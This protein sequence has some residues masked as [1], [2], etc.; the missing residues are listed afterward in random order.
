MPS[1]PSQI[2]VLACHSSALSGQWI[3]AKWAPVA[4]THTGPSGRSPSR[5]SQHNFVVSGQIVD[6]ADILG[7]PNG[8]PSPSQLPAVCLTSRAAMPDTDTGGLGPQVP[9]NAA[10]AAE[11]ATP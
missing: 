11:Q 3:V 9:A 4:F 1:S 7:R 6:V 5:A 8:P 10:T 2:D